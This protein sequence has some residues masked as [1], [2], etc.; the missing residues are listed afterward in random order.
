MYQLYTDR[1]KDEIKISK[2]KSYFR[3]SI[4]EHEA[5]LS[6]GKIIYYNMYYSFCT[7]R[8]VLVKHAKELK[9]NWLLAARE[10]V[11]RIEQIEI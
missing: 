2:M 6:P 10:K 1:E 3:G 11:I 5:K 7:N 4:Q 8:S 9:L